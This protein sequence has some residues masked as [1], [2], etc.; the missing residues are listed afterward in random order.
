MGDLINFNSYPKKIKLGNRQKRIDEK[1]T[2]IKEEHR[3][4]QEKFK[5]KGKKSSG[6]LDKNQYQ[7]LF[8][9]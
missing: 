6:I 8:L 7:L 1:T 3:R 5:N 2:R 9:G 4:L